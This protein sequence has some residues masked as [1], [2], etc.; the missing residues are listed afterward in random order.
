[1]LLGPT[2]GNNY[3]WLDRLYAYGLRNDTFDAA[4]VHTDTACLTVGPDAFYRENGRLGQYTFLGYRE[5]RA[6]LLAHGADKP[7]WMTELGWTATQ[8]SGSS[9]LCSSGLWAGKKKSGVTEAEQA[10]FLKSAYHC[11]ALDPAVVPVALWFTLRDRRDG[12]D[13]LRHYG[14]L[15]TSGAAKPALGAFKDV[16]GAANADPFPGRACGDFDAPAVTI[17]APTDGQ[18]FTGS[19]L[20]RASATDG[21]GTGLA[22]ITLRADGASGEIRNFTA[23][24]ADGKAVELDWQGAKKLALGKHTIT[25]EALDANG[26]TLSKTVAVEKVKT[27]AATLVTRTTTGKVRCKGRLCVLRGRVGGPPGQSVGGKVQVL[28]QI[29]TKVRRKGSRKTRLAYKTIHKGLKQANTPF[30]FSQRLKR[31]GR[32]RV[33]VRYQ[34][35]APLKPSASQYLSFRVR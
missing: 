4:A 17:H 18:Q 22:R 10:D 16:S 9:P 30:T 27:L 11:L 20:I 1:V 33:Q 23:G 24:L 13:E 7:V 29:Q 21:G 32:W 35:A 5:V 34:G 28:W 26:N 8:G 6:T 31:R 14:L 25:V 12:V 2:T 3:G 15:R 19:L